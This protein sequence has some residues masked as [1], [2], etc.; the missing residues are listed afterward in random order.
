MAT[1]LLSAAGAA[2]GGSI[3]GGVLGLSSAVIGRAVGATIGRSIDQKLLGGGSETV[4]TGQIDRM[5]IMG[6]SEGAV[7]PS[8][9]GRMRVSGNVIWTS[10]YRETVSTSQASGS[11][12]TP[13][14]PTTSEYSYSI[15]LAIALGEGPI[16]GIGRVWVD[17]AIFPTG[18]LNLRVY[19]GTED[20]VPDPVISAIEGADDVPAYRG[21]A[22]VVIE[23]LDVTQFGNRVPQ[24]SFEVIR[25]SE[26]PRLDV[27]MAEGVQAVALMPGTGEFA[28]STDP[29]YKGGVSG[30]D[31]AVNVNSAEGRPDL[32]VSLD[33]MT[34]ELPNCNATSLIVSWFGDDLRAGNCRV[35]PKVE[36]TQ[37]SGPRVGSIPVGGVSDDWA[38]SGVTRAQ[39]EAV[40]QVD[41]RPVYGGT[42]TDASIIQAIQT[43][44]ERGQDVM[45]YPFLLMEI[46]DGNSLPDP[47]SGAPSQPALPWRGR[48]STQ[49][50]P[51]QAGSTDQTAAARLE[52][53]AF[54]GAA[55]PSDFTINGTTVSYSGQ[56]GW[57]YRR[58]ILHYAN[59]C[60]AA[61]GVASFCIGSEMRSLTQIRD[62]TGAFP[63]VEAF[64]QLASEVRTI[65]GAD[66]KI[67]Y[68]ADWSEYFGY[69]PPDGSGDVLYHL[70]PLWSDDEI[71]F[72]GIDNYMPLADW[73][74]GDDHLD[75]AEFHT[76]YDLDYLRGNIAGGEGYDWYYRDPEER[77]L[78][79]RT[80]IEDGAHNEPWIY[81]NKDLRNWWTLPHYERSGGTRNSIPTAWEPRCKPIWFTELVCAAVDKGPNQP[82]KFLDPKSSES[83]LPHFSSGRRDDYAQMQFLRAY[84]SY[85]AEPENNP[86]SEVYNGPMVDM[87]KAFIWA[88]DARPWPDFPNNTNVWSDGANHVA[89]HWLT[90]RTGTQPLS[91]VVASICEASGLTQYDV[92]QLHG[93]VRG[94]SV[95]GLETAR[96]QLQPL[97]VSYGFD[98]VEQGGIL[99]FR[100][101]D[102]APVITVADAD[103]TIEGS[104]GV[105]EQSRA[106]E[107]EVVGQVRLGY[108]EADGEFAPRVAD[109]RFPDDAV[110]AKSQNDMPLSFIAS[111]ARA[112]SERWLSEAR[113][114]RD[115]VRVTLPPSRG[116]IYAGDVMRLSQ[117]GKGLLYRVDRIEDRGA[118][119]VEAVRI[120]Q[121]IY[122]PS[123]STE[124]IPELRPFAVPVPVS[125]Q[126]MDLPL[127]TG[128]EVPHAP[129][130]A[131]FA[132]PWPGGAGVYAAPQDS[133]YGLNTIIG[134][135]SVIGV[136][137]SVLSAATPGLWDRGPALRVSLLGGTLSAVTPEAV[138][139]GANVAAIGDGSNDNWEVFQFTDAQLIAPGVF[140]LSVRLRGQAG[141]D[142][143]M[144][145]TWPEGSTFVLI[146][147]APEQIN[148]DLSARDLARHY[149]VGPAAR[150]VS[151]PSYQHYVEA[152]KGVG[153]RPYAPAGLSQL[154]DGNDDLFRWHR[155]TRIDGDSWV[156]TEV[157]LGEDNE[158]YLLRISSNGTVIRQE[159]LTTTGWTY[160]AAMRAADGVTGTYTL[161]IAQLS[162]SFGPGLFA[163]KEINA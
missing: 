15:N 66:T 37:S 53:D 137:Q 56:P 68:A 46:L 11:K 61:G 7:V 63:A 141:T 49:K 94:F 95:D 25:G 120:E 157:P 47:W 88:W 8:V 83:G 128:S 44:N 13:S 29:V 145:D 9:Y 127:L 152:F 72:I 78:Q 153:L 109:A 81:R 151:D 132:Q 74:D 144:P 155:R 134:S 87:S 123:D 100:N 76:M 143:L 59:L 79:I 111:E 3:G 163:R 106:P 133:D 146:D 23:D 58:F 130:L 119:I 5:R 161:E 98:A 35:L 126:F 103:Y 32:N 70:D 31:R 91:N 140:D 114:A 20:Q 14:A 139:N 57:G 6:A 73:R 21:L 156:S 71:D 26:T 147:G 51:G 34:R 69:Q 38:V 107:A 33:A 67:G 10:N 43:L 129:Y 24:F 17:G 142:G 125:A 117:N 86:T 85:Y 118:R 84:F 122:T 30:G 162:Q 115:T 19:H 116:D 42:P 65:L 60:A 160:T 45:F 135:P 149:R 154:K 148:L 12:G 89:G 18:D 136:T 92:S 112:I 39:A 104:D 52:V 121:Q 108:I 101:R 50:A 90:G 77:E 1:I 40:A 80:P 159:N 75:K 27:T 64:V 150:P 131:A 110:N 22:Y 62:D 41:G 99:K 124:E 105:L 96:A 113:V 16:T 55:Q 2:I 54:M 4:E 97:M 158:A 138:L 28:L 36:T 102:A 82:N 93:I 48:I